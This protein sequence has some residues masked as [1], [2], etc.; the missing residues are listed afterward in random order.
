MH[1][2]SIGPLCDAGRLFLS[3]Q[4][5]AMLGTRILLALSWAFTALALDLHRS[6]PKS[7]DLPES[8]IITPNG[9]HFHEFTERYLRSNS[10][11]Y[12]IVIIANTEDDVS[13]AVKYATSQHVSIPF[14]QKF[15]AMDPSGVWRLCKAV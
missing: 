11:D 10:P 6:R 3:R 4:K 1:K 12:S 13:K 7:I 14:S 2:E 8:Q 15:L 9:P 5:L